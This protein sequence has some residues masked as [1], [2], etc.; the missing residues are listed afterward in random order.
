M[1]QFQNTYVHLTSYL[2]VNKRV[3]AVVVGND[4]SLKHGNLNSRNFYSGKR[5]NKLWVFDS[6]DIQCNV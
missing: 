1:H 2:E 6:C 4:F 5:W 3:K